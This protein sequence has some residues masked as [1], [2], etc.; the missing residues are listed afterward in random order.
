MKT[1]I[2]IENPSELKTVRVNREIE[3]LMLTGYKSN[4][5]LLRMD[6]ITS[7]KVQ[8]DI[9]NHFRIL[10]NKIAFSLDKKDYSLN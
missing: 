7:E 8:S 2:V 9:L 4:E 5:I 1:V 10:K 6:F 3:S